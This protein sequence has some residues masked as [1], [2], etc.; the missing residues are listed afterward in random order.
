M[1]NQVL[2][3]TY[4]SKKKEEEEEGNT[5][6]RLVPDGLDKNICCVIAYKRI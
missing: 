4:W 1:V 3:I 2:K 6:D 5:R